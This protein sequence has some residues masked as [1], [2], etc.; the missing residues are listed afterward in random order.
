MGEIPSLFAPNI[1]VGEYHAPTYTSCPVTESESIRS[2]VKLG[3]IQHLDHGV[4]AGN[5]DQRLGHTEFQTND[6]SVDIGQATPSEG[7]E[8]RLVHQTFHVEYV[9]HDR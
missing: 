7:I 8:L 9:S 5:D 2:A 4:S 6:R 3:S 1:A